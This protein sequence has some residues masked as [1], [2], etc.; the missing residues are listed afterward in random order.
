[1]CIR[2]LST[3]A[4]FLLFVLLYGT[5]LY[6]SFYTRQLDLGW[7]YD[8]FAPLLTASIIFSTALSVYL[9]VSS[10]RKGLL[11]STHGNTG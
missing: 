4:A 2:P 11:L 3:L 1:M 9:Y 10:F 6:F 5:V 7:L 8:Q